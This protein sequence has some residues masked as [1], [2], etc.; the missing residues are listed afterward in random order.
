[1]LLKRGIKEVRKI[2]IFSCVLQNFIINMSGMFAN[3][4]LIKFM[5]NINVIKK[6]I[7]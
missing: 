7:I 5:D 2:S 1:M 6:I 3:V 4:V